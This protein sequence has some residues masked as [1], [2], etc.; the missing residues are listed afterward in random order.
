[1]A[2]GLVAWSG[3][4]EKDF[5]RIAAPTLVL[6][7]GAD[8]L[9]PDGEAV[10]RAIPGA[11]CVVVPGAGHARHQA[12][13]RWTTP[14]ASAHDARRA[15][16]RHPAFVGAFLFLPALTARLAAGVGAVIGFFVAYSLV[17][18]RVV[19]PDLTRSEAAFHLIRSS[20]LRASVPAVVSLLRPGQPRAVWFLDARTDSPVVP[21]RPLA[22]LRGP[23]R[24]YAFARFSHRRESL[25][26]P[27]CASRASAV[28]T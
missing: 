24:G 18:F 15:V 12:R 11:R 2:A 19:H 13:P 17:A 4:R 16:D 5:A 20:R 10:A 22:R 6:A 25:L 23:R 21:R 7:G 28:I 14:E 8:L 26:R 3:T 9:T 1:M 27:W